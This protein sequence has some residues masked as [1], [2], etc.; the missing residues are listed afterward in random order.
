MPSRFCREIGLLSLE[1]PKPRVNVDRFNYE[2]SYKQNIPN[3]IVNSN[4]VELWNKNILSEKKEEYK[5]KKD[6][7]IYQV[8]QK[9]E[10]PKFGE[11]IILQI[12]SDHL[13]GDIDFENF[14]KKSLMLEL[15]P[16]TIIE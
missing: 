14:G 13:V 4:K 11:G 15:A 2:D 1:R 9:V 5:P 7:S 8:G 6:V 3:R 12:S 16:L 10:H